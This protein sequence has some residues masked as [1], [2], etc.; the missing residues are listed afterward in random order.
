MV[1][2]AGLGGGVRGTFSLLEDNE[3]ARSGGGGPAGGDFSKLDVDAMNTHFV[4]CG[5][6]EREKEARAKG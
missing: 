1:E 5:S 3:A 2:E 4:C 6:W